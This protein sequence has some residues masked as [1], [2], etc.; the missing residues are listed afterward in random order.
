[1]LDQNN[2]PPSVRFLASYAKTQ[3]LIPVGAATEMKGNAYIGLEKV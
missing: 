2:L 1:M 3:N